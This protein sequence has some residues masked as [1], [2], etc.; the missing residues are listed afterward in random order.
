MSPCL[1]SFYGL[2]LGIAVANAPSVLPTCGVTAKRPLS[3]PVRRSLPQRAAWGHDVCVQML[4]AAA[5]SQ[6]YVFVSRAIFSGR[7]DQVESWACSGEHSR[8]EAREK[9]ASLWEWSLGL[10]WRAGAAAKC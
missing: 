5:I 7:E 2:L 6:P 8:I 9:L 10:S 1:F 4:V 3:A